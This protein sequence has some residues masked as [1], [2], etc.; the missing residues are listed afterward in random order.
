MKNGYLIID[1]GTGNTRAA[2]VSSR[3]KVIAQS[4][5]DTAYQVE[6]EDACSFSPAMLLKNVLEVARRAVKQAED[7]RVVAVSATSTRQGAVLL[8]KNGEGWLGLPNIDN[9]GAYLE[10]QLDGD[11]IYQLS[12]RWAMRYF[13][14]LKIRGYFDRYPEKW[15]KLSQFTSI[16]DWIGFALTGNLVYEHSQACETLL[17]DIEKSCWSDE[18]CGLMGI[19]PKYL[20]KLQQSGSLLGYVKG[21]V[22]DQIGIDKVPFIVGGGDTQVALL[23]TSAQGGD[24]AVIAG[25]TTP[26]AMLTDCCQWEPRQRFWTSKHVMADEYLLET[27]AG[28]TGLNY[29]RFKQNFLPSISYEKL[30]QLM[31][32]MEAPKCLCCMSTMEFAAKRSFAFGGFSFPTPFQ[33]DMTPVDLA[34]AML[35]DMACGIKHNVKVLEE[36]GQ[37]EGRMVGAGGGLRSSAFCRIIAGMTGRTLT[38]CKG[39]ESASAKGTAHLISRYLGT[40][41]KQEEVLTVY[42]PKE[43]PWMEDVYGRWLA[44]REKLNS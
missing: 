24:V 14:A 33:A 34:Y 12:G 2:V 42:E 29:Q 5:V 18:L 36:Y 28:V 22:A 11:K 25:T 6:G 40:D 31:Q 9:R 19:H 13:T 41:E 1:F 21:Q 8:D 23:A 7:T 43:E 32:N 17:Y 39:F 27:N 37:K 30:N 26:V 20:P 44:L 15:E 16:S 10:P 38:L 35:V 4:V 3:G